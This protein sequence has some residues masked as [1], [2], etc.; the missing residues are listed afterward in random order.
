MSPAS[1]RLPI[2]LSE[3]EILFLEG[4][5]HQAKRTGGFRLSKAAVVR[6]LIEVAMRMEIDVSGVRDEEELKSRIKMATT[7]EKN[8]WHT[9]H[10]LK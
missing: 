9:N 4:L 5:G 2:N 6:A 7:L 8:K 10:D 3:E 1:Y